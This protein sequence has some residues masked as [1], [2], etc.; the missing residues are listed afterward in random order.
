MR[1]EHMCV[2]F[3]RNPAIESG[4]PAPVLNTTLYARFTSLDERDFSS[5]LLS[6]MRHGFGG[7]L[8]NKKLTQSGLMTYATD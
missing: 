4:M 7:Y 6:V 2:V 3:D 1:A 8:E 5:W